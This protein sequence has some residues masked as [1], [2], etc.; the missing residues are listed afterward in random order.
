MRWALAIGAMA[1]GVG[2]VL[3]SS[4]AV[5]AAPKAAFG[6]GITAVYDGRMINL[7]NGWS[8]AQ[9]CISFSTSD[10]RCYATSQEADAALGYSAASDPLAQ[11][12]LA[13]GQSL[14]AAAPECASGW[15]C[16]WEAIN[17]GGRRLIFQDDYWQDLSE[18]GFANVMSSW[19]NNQAAGDIAYVAD[20][21]LGTLPLLAGA[22]TANIGA[23]WNDA[24][25]SVQG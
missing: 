22:Y 6:D 10:V 14:A 23:L 2:T 24:A 17:G 4:T 9:S 15:V 1:I 5:Q 12:A 8:G 25:D 21:T 7:R 13:K 19:R 18:Y 20:D 11:R 16:L 3:A